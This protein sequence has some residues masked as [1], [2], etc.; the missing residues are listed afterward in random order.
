MYL[1]GQ[2]HSSDGKLIWTVKTCIVAIET[3][4]SPHIGNID[5]LR[6]DRMANLTAISAGDANEPAVVFVHGL[7]GD[8]TGTWTSE[9]CFWPTLVAEDL[10]SWAVWTLSYD[11]ALS[12]WSG[13]AMPLPEQGNTILD[14]LKNEPRLS[15]RSL[16]FVCHSMG[17]LVIKTAV[18]H[19]ANHRRLEYESL[20]RRVA[21]IVFVATPHSGA[22]LA[23]LADVVKP[24]L[25]TNPQVANLA[26]HDPHLRTLS[27][28]FQEA[29]GRF[30]FA[31]RTYAE[32]AGVLV[33]RRFLGIN[34]GY[35][36]V[37]VDPS[38]SVPHVAR[39]IVVSLPED[40]FSICKPKSRASQIH[41]S[42]IGFLRESE[43]QVRQG[44]P[45][46][47]DEPHVTTIASPENRSG[48]QRHES[49]LRIPRDRALTWLTELVTGGESLQQY[50][51]D[52]DGFR[53]NGYFEAKHA[54]EE[55]KA[56]VEAAMREIFVNAEALSQFRAE[57]RSY[58]REARELFIST[59]RTLTGR[60]R[61]ITDALGRRD[62]AELAGARRPDEVP[63]DV[64]LFR[65]LIEILPPD[66]NIHWLRGANFA[67]F[68]FETRNL[69]QLDSFH[70]KWRGAA[71]EFVEGALDKKL[72]KL[73][74]QVAAFEA[75]I[76]T[77]TWPVSSGLQSVPPE[78]ETSQPAR[79]DQVV[80]DIHKSADQIVRTYDS[81]LREGREKLGESSAK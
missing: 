2:R 61:A 30:G 39:G 8:D 35:R 5:H 6:E 7:N 75:L 21:G 65:A 69:R 68:A 52:I 76:A 24:V 1:A 14:L 64:K 58:Q 28:Q 74:K 44:R 53:S 42:L 22:A 15:D 51:D 19:A 41:S 18:A 48:S 11:G 38:S 13:N 34:W 32:T 72:K 45:A 70:E 71:Y 60:L 12:G 43:E 80:R 54:L 9:N 37:I 29:Q 4:S 66:G 17:G 20:L 79:F 40:H 25:R 26:L 56:R 59:G 23:I 46:R 77:Q 3:D 33:G 49:D 81:I 67:G 57:H 50:A 27:E 78:W 31:V 47:E 10:P 63:A 36:Q 62:Q 16:F 55:W 73:Q